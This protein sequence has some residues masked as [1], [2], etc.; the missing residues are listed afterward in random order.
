MMEIWVTAVAET[1]SVLE[2]GWGGEAEPEGVD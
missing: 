2:G 1:R